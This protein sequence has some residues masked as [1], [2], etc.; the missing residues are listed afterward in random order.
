MHWQ[1]IENAPKDGTNVLIYDD[2]FGPEMGRWNGRYWRESGTCLER[3]PTHFMFIAPHGEQQPES[4]N[5]RLLQ[6]AEKVTAGQ[7]YHTRS[8]LYPLHVAELEAAIEAAKQATEGNS[9][10]IL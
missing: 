2:E 8:T 9:N 3:N 1:P 5:Q 4:V 7:C 10:E 6:A